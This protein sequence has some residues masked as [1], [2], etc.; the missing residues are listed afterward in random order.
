MR[1]RSVHL[2]TSAVI[3]LISRGAVAIERRVCA[4]CMLEIFRDDD[5]GFA[6]PSGDICPRRCR[7][8]Y[9]G[10]PMRRIC[11]M[12]PFTRATLLLTVWP[13]SARIAFTS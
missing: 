7:S 8:A 2:A 9:P 4:M 6:H 5:V 13:G 1:W 12:R 10:A 11:P 3:S